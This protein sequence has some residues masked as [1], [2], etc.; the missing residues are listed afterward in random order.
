MTLQ[1]VKDRLFAHFSTFIDDD[2][3]TQY[4]LQDAA[5]TMFYVLDMAVLLVEKFGSL[6]AALDAE[7]VTRCQDCIAYKSEEFTCLGILGD[8]NK[9]M[10]P[11][12]HCSRALTKEQYEKL[13][14]IAEKMERVNCISP[15]ELKTL[16]VTETEE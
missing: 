10:L 13:R 2:G 1:E 8:E 15:G 11:D 7:K 14:Q 6:E 9:V 3:I 12:D 5:N 4:Y 16:H